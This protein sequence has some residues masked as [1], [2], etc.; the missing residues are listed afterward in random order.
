MPDVASTVEDPGRRNRRP[1]TEVAAEVKRK[2][3]KGKDKAGE[4]PA[5]AGPKIG[6][7]TNFLE[8]EVDVQEQ[9]REEQ[10]QGD[11]RDV[12]GVSAQS[13][14]TASTS[15]DVGAAQLSTHP[16]A[17]PR[18][19]RRY[20][21]VVRAIDMSEPETVIFSNFCK[22]CYDNGTLYRCIRPE[23]L[24]PLRLNEGD[25]R[26]CP[27]MHEGHCYYVISYREHPAE[28]ISPNELPTYKLRLYARGWRNAL[29]T[30][31]DIPTSTTDSN[32]KQTIAKSPYGGLV[33]GA[34]NLNVPTARAP[35]AN[36]DSSTDQNSGPT[37]TQQLVLS[38]DAQ[39]SDSRPDLSL[40]EGR[41][42]PGPLE[43]HRNVRPKPQPHSGI[44]GRP[45][46]VE[47]TQ[48][49]KQSFE[50][51]FT[52]QQ[53][54][55]YRLQLD[56]L[57]CLESLPNIHHTRTNLGGSETGTMED[58]LRAGPPRILSTRERHNPNGNRLG[59]RASFERDRLERAN[60]RG[61]L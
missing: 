61:L 37:E 59:T 5:F 50:P 26:R 23:E 48:I 3:I 6:G 16:L 53:E 22:Y 29:A 33:R 24:S 42:S 57:K 12:G 56:P 8:F 20:W 55:E 2:V 52:L 34:I 36:V 9:K 39:P 1:P 58:I 4:P 60:R 38:N 14:T 31:L 10:D 47:D 27:V 19:W 25:L 51:A 54:R 13:F 45:A 49:L 18:G 46:W 41:N 32:T 44:Q 7:A 40:I 21:G 35:E 30:P 17:A 15:S 43:K 11:I 28:R